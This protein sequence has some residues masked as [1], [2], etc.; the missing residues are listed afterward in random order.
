MYNA[1]LHEA[2][3]R[4]QA[5]R[6]DAES[7]RVS[8]V[9][10]NPHAL[11]AADFG[12]AAFC[13]SCGH[14]SGHHVPPGGGYPEAALGTLSKPHRVDVRLLSGN[15]YALHTPDPHPHDWW[16]ANFPLIWGVVEHYHIRIVP[17][18]NLARV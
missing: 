16:R 12:C 1:L 7:A 14:V 9:E 13:K 6:T 4:G 2:L 17:D 3:G 10:P 8:R 5:V 15:R 18:W 11:R